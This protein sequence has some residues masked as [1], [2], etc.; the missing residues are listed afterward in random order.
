VVE[1]IQQDFTPEKLADHLQKI[2]AGP[3]R[4]RQ[5]SDLQRLRERLG[6]GGAAQRAARAIVTSS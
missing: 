3:E 1:L 4:D 6:S 5:L 2:I